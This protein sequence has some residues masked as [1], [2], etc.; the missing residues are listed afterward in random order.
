MSLLSCLNINPLVPV[1]A[2]AVAAVADGR[3][4]GVKSFINLF[5]I[6]ESIFS[7]KKKRKKK[8]VQWFN[9]GGL[10]EGFTFN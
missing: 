2:T 7:Q 6:R 8:K 3:G 9:G 5:N 4:R 10:V 1:S